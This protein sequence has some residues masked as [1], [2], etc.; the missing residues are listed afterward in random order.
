MLFDWS[1]FSF[2]LVHIS[3]LDP[4]Q[5]G[6]KYCVDLDALEKEYVIISA[7]YLLSLRD[8]TF[9]LSGTGLIF[10]YLVKEVSCIEQNNVIDKKH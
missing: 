3:G 4:E 7:Q 2:S 10:E 8:G 5:Q 1:I 9:K 6:S